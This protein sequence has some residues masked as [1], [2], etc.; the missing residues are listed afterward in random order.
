[1]TGIKEKSCNLLRQAIF[2]DGELSEALKQF[3]REAKP[4]TSKLGKLTKDQHTAC[5]NKAY[6]DVLVCELS[7]SDVLVC[8]L[9]TS[10]SSV[11]SR[12]SRGVYFLDTN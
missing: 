10:L 9:S 5:H 4:G 1:M 2:A 12:F 11:C 3:A 8:A 7:T 6:L